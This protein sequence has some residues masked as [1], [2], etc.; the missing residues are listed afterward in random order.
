MKNAQVQS[1][2]FREGQYLIKKIGPIFNNFFCE[3]PKGWAIGDT[4]LLIMA[5]L[6]IPPVLLYS[7]SV[8]P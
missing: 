8:S 4:A 5:L 2:V 7:I 6:S 3:D 1:C